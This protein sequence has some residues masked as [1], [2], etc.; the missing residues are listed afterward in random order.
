MAVD[1]KGVEFHLADLYR[2][3]DGIK[4]ARLGG[5]GADD[6]KAR[7]QDGVVEPHLQRGRAHGWVG[8]LGVHTDTLLGDT[9]EQVFLGVGGKGEGRRGGEGRREEGERERE[10]GGRGREGM[11]GGEGR[12]GMERGRR[13]REKR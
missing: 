1:E 10:E 3:P 13:G 9:G 6:L 7:L 8:R 4:I 5:G 2:F 12:G 11:G